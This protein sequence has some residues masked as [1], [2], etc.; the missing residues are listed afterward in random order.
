MKLHHAV[1]DAQRIDVRKI[2]LAVVRFDLLG[3][4][5]LLFLSLLFENR[6]EIAAEQIGIDRLPH[7]VPVAQVALFDIVVIELALG[8]FLLHRR[9]R[10][11]VRVVAVRQRLPRQQ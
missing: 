6:I 7:T 10:F 5:T 4:F 3:G 9:Q 8:S 1:L 2:P 11:T